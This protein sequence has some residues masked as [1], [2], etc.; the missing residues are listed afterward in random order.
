M[1]VSVL[2][3]ELARALAGCLPADLAKS[4]E[5]VPSERPE[6]WTTVPTGALIV[7]DPALLAGDSVSLA[8]IGAVLTTAGARV[9]FYTS[10]SAESMRAVAFAAV[11]H[12]VELWITGVDDRAGEFAR[13]V[14]RLAAHDLVDEVLTRLLSAGEALRPPVRAALIAL[15]AAP[16]RF[17]DADDVARVAMT[18][19][20]NLDRYLAEY[21]LGTARRLIV[22]AKIVHGVTRLG[23]R[24]GPARSVRLWSYPSPPSPRCW[25]AGS[26]FSARR[27]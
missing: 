17:F 14:Q 22:A 15:F 6:W 21:G 24:D 27:S 12:P 2:T 9:V 13:R 3:P 26:F 19:R 16:E 23:G 7:L 25:P 10:F 8:A 11:L 5:F 4:I 20:R 1:I 18:S